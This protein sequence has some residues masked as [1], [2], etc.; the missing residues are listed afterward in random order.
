MQVGAQSWQWMSGRTARFAAIGR[1]TRRDAA[2]INSP[3]FKVLVD[4]V[5]A[6][7]S[8][9]FATLRIVSASLVNH[10][11]VLFSLLPNSMLFIKFFFCC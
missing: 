2:F 1:H 9:C 8:Q 5:A 11:A 4:A 7:I 6:R 10:G 3:G